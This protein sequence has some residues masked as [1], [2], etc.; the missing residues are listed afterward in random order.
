MTAQHEIIRAWCASRGLS[1]PSNGDCMALVAAL[2]A[3]TRLD[4]FI[5]DVEASGDAEKRA[6]QEQT[7]P[8][9]WQLLFT[10]EDGLSR[11]ETFYD[12]SHLDYYVKHTAEM[13]GLKCIVVPM[14]AAI[15]SDLMGGK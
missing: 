10:D 4:H 2:T 13:R 7:G 15:N 6:V 3:P 9:A 11:R 1:E 5:E 12:M 8:I 14:V